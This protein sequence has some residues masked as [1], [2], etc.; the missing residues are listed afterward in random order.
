MLLPV[1]KKRRN[2]SSFEAIMLYI[3]VQFKVKN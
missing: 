1:E 2:D 3:V